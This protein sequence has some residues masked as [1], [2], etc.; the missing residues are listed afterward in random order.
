MALSQRAIEQ[1]ADDRRNTDSH[2]VQASSS[3]MNR[4]PPRK[5]NG[6]GKKCPKQPELVPQSR[7]DD[8]GV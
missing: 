5:A 6:Q 1:P 4:S 3:D 7:H 2:A 8:G